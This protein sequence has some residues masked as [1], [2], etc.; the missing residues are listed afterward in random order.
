MVS[1]INSSR[2]KK[3]LGGGGGVSPSGLGPY[4]RYRVLRG[5]DY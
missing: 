1:P 3:V 4:V 5:L 2:P